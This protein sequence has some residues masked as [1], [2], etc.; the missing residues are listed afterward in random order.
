LVFLF[1][2][3]GAVPGMEFKSHVKRKKENHEEGDSM[4]PEKL[5]LLADSKHKLILES[6]GWGMA[7]PQEE[8]I[9]ALEAKL[10]KTAKGTKRESPGNCNENPNKRRKSNG[11]Q[12][13]KAKPSFM[14]KAPPKGDLVNPF[15]PRQWNDKPWCHCCKLTGGKSNGEWRVH[16]PT[17]CQGKSHVFKN[18]EEPGKP[19]N[20]NDSRKLKLAKAHAAVSEE[21]ES[22]NESDEDE[23]LD[24]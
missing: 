20:K 7:N 9:L 18:K 10:A 17:D 8:K 1:K 15:K 23:R 6:G 16:D 5:M 13:K 12:P 19:K 4:T 11:N 14:E 22:E 3:H 2:G 24:E 21:T